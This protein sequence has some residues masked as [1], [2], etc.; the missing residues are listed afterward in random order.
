MD[1]YES[2]AHSFVVKIW[3]EEVLADTGQ[4]IWRGRVTHV[5]DGQQRYFSNLEELVRF[6]RIYLQDMGV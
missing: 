6:F 1:S 4:V 2:N 5:P 3:I